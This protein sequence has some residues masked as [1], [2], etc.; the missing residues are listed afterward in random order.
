MAGIGRSVQPRG[1][2]LN[3]VDNSRRRVPGLF[4]INHLQRGSAEVD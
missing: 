2:P 4:Q 1:A 3:L